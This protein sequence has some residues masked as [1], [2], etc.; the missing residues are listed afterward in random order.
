MFGEIRF[1]KGGA[2]PPPCTSFGFVV[3]GTLTFRFG[4]KNE[5]EWWRAAG[6]IVVIPTNL[7]KWAEA[8]RGTME[9]EIFCPPGPNR[10][11]KT[12]ATQR[13]IPYPDTGGPRS[14]ARPVAHRG[15]GQ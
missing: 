1:K 7:T 8:L 3:T 10:L 5:D 15:R 4:D 9:F 12:S 2:V 6:V 14:G 11:D 13:A